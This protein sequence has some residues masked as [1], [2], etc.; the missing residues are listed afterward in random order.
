[1]SSDIK[2]QMS[3]REAALN[4]SQLLYQW[5]NHP[6]VRMNSFNESELK[7]EEHNEWVKSKIKDPNTFMLIAELEQKR[8][9]VIRFEKCGGEVV[10]SV[11]VDPDETGKGW[12]TRIIQEGS[13]LFFKK[14]SASRAISARIKKDNEASLRAFQKA[15]YQ[16]KE[17][18]KEKVVL[19]IV[20]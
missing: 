18:D 13:D 1:M 9:G 10:V 3:L 12:G 15:G 2:I 11:N 17:E 16:L 4:D 8:I 7:W 19:E 5:R 20:R 6:S 14:F